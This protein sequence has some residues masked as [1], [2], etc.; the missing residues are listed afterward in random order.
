MEKLEQDVEMIKKDY[1]SFRCGNK[2]RSHRFS[3]IP[4]Q[5]VI[6]DEKYLKVVRPSLMVVDYYPIHSLLKRQKIKRSTM[7]FS[8]IQNLW[9]SLNPGNIRGISKPLYLVVIECFY[10]QF[11]QA[12]ANPRLVDI[13]LS[14]DTEIDF[15]SRSSLTFCEFYD[16]IFEVVDCL[17]RS[18]LSSEYSRSIHLTRGLIL[19]SSKFHSINLYSKLHLS[20]SIRPS[21]YNWMQ[22]C[23]R[24]LT[25]SRNLTQLPEILKNSSAISLA[26]KFLTRIQQ[27]PAKEELPMK[28]GL[29]KYVKEREG[30][31][32]L[33]S[34]TPTIPGQTSNSF[35]RKIEKIDKYRKTPFSITP[36]K[37]RKESFLIETV[38]EDRIKKRNEDN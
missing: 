2:W 20:D 16:I 4:G 7:L 26:P 30:K 13:H 34:V 8:E 11:Q 25:P 14:Q 3:F 9:Q 28:W 10:K 6:E 36:S 38:V 22:S 21:M 27:R 1:S 33:R 31:S 18:S 29:L 37:E 17:S 32:P 35:L 5:E 19:Q 12:M 23:L 24:S 15:K